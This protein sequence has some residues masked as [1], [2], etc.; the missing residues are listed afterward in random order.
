MHQK[1]FRR[2]PFA[3]I[4]ILVLL[5]M[6]CLISMII[7][8][9]G[10]DLEQLDENDQAVLTEYN[11]LCTSLAEEEV[12]EDFHL[13]DQT[14]L[15]MPRMWN[16]Y[17]INPSEP[18]SGVFAKKIRLPEDWKISVY[19]LA[20]V[21][22][23]L[24]QFRF[25]GNFNTMG[26]TYSLLGND[27]YYVK[28]NRDRAVKDKWSSEHFT[29]FLSHE[30]FHYYMQN[31]WPDG[32]R[33]YTDNMTAE[34]IDLLGKEYAALGKIQSQLL[35]DEPDHDALVSAAEEYVGIKE[36][37]LAA[38]PD[39][40]QK[41]IE[42]ETVEGSATYVGIKASERVGYDYGVM[43]FD[44]KKNV[45]FDE[46]IPQ[47]QAGNL[48]HSFFADRMPYETGALLC[49]LMDELDV[50]DWQGVLNQQTKENPETL[51][52][53]LKEWAE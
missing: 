52:S 34:D 37:R 35:S 18:V 28:Y 31:Q 8:Q 38:D 39:Y 49:L 11:Q 48:D 5:L 26:K 32:S 14:I 21:T 20:A 47:Y 44:N 13:E 53:V 9:T 45:S 27:V 4:C 41:E 33:F 50:P 2:L 7:N 19:R 17:L 15:A 42:M 3:A 24:M 16:G 46:V 10:A 12:W 51:Y 29:T 30:A 1:K 22:P 40:V 6:I 23:G 36:L 43:Y 25:D